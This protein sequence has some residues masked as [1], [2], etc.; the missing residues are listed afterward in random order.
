MMETLKRPYSRVEYFCVE[1][2][3]GMISSRLLYALV[4]SAGSLFSA[5]FFKAFPQQT[6]Q[7]RSA[8]GQN[9]LEASYCELRRT[10]ELFDGKTIRVRGIYERASE[11]SALFI[12][13]A[14]ICQT[15]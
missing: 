2:C 3:N 15:S 6:C 13:A 4:I 5:S 1:N 10:P 11:M 7:P 8:A 12:S 14:M 9:I